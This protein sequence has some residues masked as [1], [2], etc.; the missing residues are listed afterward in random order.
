MS[1]T[2]GTSAARG[3]LTW[4]AMTR[5]EG[6]PHLKF[7]QASEASYS[8]MP[9]LVHSAGWRGDG[10]DGSACAWCAW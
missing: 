9:L 6:I 4:R 3:A 1:L 8:L 2:P 7:H 5:E 10:L